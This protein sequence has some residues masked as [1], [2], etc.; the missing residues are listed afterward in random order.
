M[1]ANWQGLEAAGTLIAA[2][3]T[4][5]T[6]LYGV[7]QYNKQELGKIVYQLRDDCA[8]INQLAS[9][10][11]G[12]LNTASFTAIAQRLT[13]S[14][15]ALVPN[16]ATA[17]EY[18]NSL[19]KM[20]KAI[21]GSAMIS[22][23]YSTPLLGRVEEYRWRLIELSNRQVE[24]FPTI[25][26]IVIAAGQVVTHVAGELLSS[27]TPR[28][29]FEDDGF[30]PPSEFWSVTRKMAEHAENVAQARASVARSFADLNQ[31]VLRR[32][33]Q[34][35]FDAAQGIIQVVAKR[36]AIASP[37][38]LREVMRNSRK[39]DRLTTKIAQTTNTWEDELPEL[40]RSIK[41]FLG[42]S[43]YMAI[44]RHCDVL[45]ERDREKG[46]SAEESVNPPAD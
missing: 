26:R 28:R 43:G 29:V 14:L 6:L 27:Y 4:V 45:L 1:S 9:Q 24:Y 42:K 12:L 22:V 11:D 23:D 38:E 21:L 20:D 46:A 13:S 19:E 32:G 40:C 15:D 7:N 33:A 35:R 18:I 37:G 36:V 16:A 10:L 5:A 17:S 3:G 2:G 34:T 39:S 44:C 31:S 25:K 41:G 8:Q 30:Y